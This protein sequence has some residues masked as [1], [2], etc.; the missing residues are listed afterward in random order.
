MA[1]T[2]VS[3][4]SAPSAAA[5]SRARHTVR[6]DQRRVGLRL[7]EP[8]IRVREIRDG[9]QPRAV[10]RGGLRLRGACRVQDDRDL[11]R[12]FLGG[13]QVLR[14]HDLA[15]FDLADRLIA[16]GRG[17]LE[18]RGLQ[19]LARVLVGPLEQRHRHGD[20]HRPIPFIHAKAIAAAARRVVGE[21]ARAA[22]IDRP[23]ECDVWI[24]RAMR[25][26]EPRGGLVHGGLAF[27]ERGRLI[28]PARGNRQGRRRR[29]QREGAGRCADVLREQRVR[30][31]AAAAC[32]DQLHDGGRM[33]CA[34]R[35]RIDARPDAGRDQ[36]LDGA[37]EDGR[38]IDG[39][40]RGGN[41]VRAGDGGEVGVGGRRAG[42]HL[43]PL[44]REARDRVA[45]LGRG[46]PGAPGAE[47]E[48]LPAD[49]SA[50]G[51]APHAAAR[52]VAGHRTG[53]RGDDGLREQ[54]ARDV[55]VRGPIELE[56]AVHTGPVRLPRQVDG[57]HRGFVLGLGHR[58]GRDS[59]RRPAR[60]PGAASAARLAPRPRARPAGTGRGARTRNRAWPRIIAR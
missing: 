41:R 26:L 51:R 38:A 13:L 19:R 22:T 35:G 43:D 29:R 53:N 39:R 3:R 49:E 7:R 11:V 8:S 18:P 15:A 10:A 45:A 37:D 17:R 44:E 32:L 40:L 59:A 36:R 16:P 12:Q 21:D 27:A 56:Q 50:D 30:R 14:G 9:R 60:P 55:E 33:L 48:R 6:V 31:V 28:R 46:H 54:Q 20:A 1:A 47:V 57:G 25:D 2:N 42:V 23:L 5:A 24:G 4:L 58:H 52:V 34:G